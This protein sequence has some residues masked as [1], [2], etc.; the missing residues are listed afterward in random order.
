MERTV[1]EAPP[2]QSGTYNCLLWR[3]ILCVQQSPILFRTKKLTGKTAF[4][5][6][7]SL[8]AK[9]TTESDMSVLMAYAEHTFRHA[10]VNKE[11]WV[12]QQL[13][14]CWFQVAKNGSEE[15]LSEM[16]LRSSRFL[17]QVMFK[18]TF[19]LSMSID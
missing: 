11:L 13:A 18:N 6:L 7:A 3:L 19:I 15:K 2:H 8:I 9:L 4:V 10:L 12:H 5:L 16:Y 17:L 1:F 14:H